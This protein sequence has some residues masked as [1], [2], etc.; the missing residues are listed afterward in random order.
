MMKG[1]AP[2]TPSCWLRRGMRTHSY[3]LAAAN[4]SWKSFRTCVRVDKF[5][6]PRAKL[7]PMKL[8]AS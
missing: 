3:C 2:N 4:N 6:S 7:Q 5:P 8:S 1:M